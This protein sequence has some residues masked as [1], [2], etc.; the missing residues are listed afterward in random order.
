MISMGMGCSSALMARSMREI[1]S[2]IKKMVLEGW[3]APM[4]GAMKAIS[5]TYGFFGSKNDF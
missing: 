4:G 2:R 3:S 5:R 1:G